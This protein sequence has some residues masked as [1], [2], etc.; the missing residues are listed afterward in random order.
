MIDVLTVFTAV[1]IISIEILVLVVL[2]KKYITTWNANK[3]QE[4][5]SDGDWMEGLLRPI[6]DILVSE[7]TDSITSRMKMELLS[8]QGVMSKQVLG[9]IDPENAEEQVLAMSNSLLQSIGYKNPNPIIVMK[10]AQGIGGMAE[11]FL[12]QNDSVNT[13]DSLP[14][15]VG[16]GLFEQ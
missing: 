2:Y 8:A 4:K 10:L 1:A 16:A 12:G 7:S 6:I 9:N 5:A 13:A 11:K 3:W 14:V 15:K